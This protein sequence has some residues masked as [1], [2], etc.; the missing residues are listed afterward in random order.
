MKNIILFY[1][2]IILGCSDCIS[3]INPI[4]INVE[5]YFRKDGTYVNPHFRTAPNYT[6]RDN[7]STKGNVNPYTGEKGWVTPDRKYL[8]NSEYLKREN[9]IEKVNK[10][11]KDFNKEMK[12]YESFKG[13]YSETIYLNDN[14]QIKFS[15][16]KS[17][18]KIDTSAYYYWYCLGLEERLI[19]P[20]DFNKKRDSI[21]FQG[22]SV[23]GSRTYQGAVI[24]SKGYFHDRTLIDGIMIHKDEKGEKIVEMNFSNGLLHGNCFE[25][26]SLGNELTCFEFENGKLVYHKFIND[27]GYTFEYINPYFKENTERFIYNV[28]EVLVEK[29]LPYKDAYIFYFYNEEGILK[30][31]S[32]QLF[33]GPN[34]GDFEYYYDNG[35][36]AQK[37]SYFQEFKDGKWKWFDVKGKVD[38][39]KHYKYCQIPDNV[40]FPD[41]SGSLLFY[42]DR[43]VKDGFWKVKCDS[44][45]NK[46]REIEYKK[47]ELFK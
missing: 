2:F 26:D 24:K 44:C 47:G 32:V 15:Y 4:H 20:Y 30:E 22:R 25:Y 14:S 5:G 8:T 17:K 18:E 43:W 41:S 38:S 29:M 6:N 21:I 46:T 39:V 23:K 16:K 13:S 45:Y 7:F 37:G 33:F 34:W 10:I 27:E 3:Q 11:I 1:V 9:N 35:S 12:D 36:L 28:N 42:N 19:L 40:S 31:K